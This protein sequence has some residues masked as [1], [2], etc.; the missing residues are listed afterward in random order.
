MI[1]A[2]TDPNTSR[3]DRAMATSHLRYLD[4]PP[5]SGTY[6][7]CGPP[8]RAKVV[9]REFAQWRQANAESDRISK[10]PLS[11]GV[12]KLFR[13]RMAPFLCSAPYLGIARH[14]PDLQSL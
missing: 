12:L 2:L 10:G 4:E 11:G 1:E 6:T 9:M 3:D 5:G 8:G 7:L 14:N 13:I